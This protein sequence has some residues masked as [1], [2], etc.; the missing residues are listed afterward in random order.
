MVRPLG[1]M[2]SGAGWL[3]SSCAMQP[4]DEPHQCPA[5]IPPLSD[6]RRLQCDG[7][8]PRMKRHTRRHRHLS[9]DC[10]RS[11]SAPGGLQAE[12]R[13]LEFRDFLP[14]ALLYHLVIPPYFS[15]VSIRTFLKKNFTK[16]LQNSFSLS[17]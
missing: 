12:R 2:E 6:R 14:P 9:A 1:D 8:F 7:T 4:L 5:G 16:I 17:G 11:Q 13:A 15:T 3:G 10:S